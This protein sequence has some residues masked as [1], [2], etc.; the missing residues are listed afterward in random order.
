MAIFG[1]S[2]PPNP[3]KP[4]LGCIVVQCI[5]LLILAL[6]T[7]QRCFAQPLSV[8]YD[9]IVITLYPTQPKAELNRLDKSILDSVFKHTLTDLFE[10]EKLLGYKL[11]GTL[12]LELYEESAKYQM[13]LQSHEVWKERFTSYYQGKSCDF[14]PIF[15]SKQEYQVHIQLRYFIAHRVLNEFLNGSSIRQK[16]TQSG[17]Y[18]FPSWIFQGL[19]AAWAGGY[20]TVAEDEHYYHRN[21]GA[22]KSPN[23]IEPLGAQVYGRKIWQQWIEQFG[24]SAITNFW[25][26]L[27]YTG[28]EEQAVEYLTG[29]TLLQWMDGEGL[30]LSKSD[31]STNQPALEQSIQD[32]SPILNVFPVASSQQWLVQSYVPD[33]ECWQILKNFETCRKTCFAYQKPHAKLMSDLAFYLVEPI[34]IHQN[35][36]STALQ[37]STDEGV[38][39]IEIDSAGLLKTIASNDAI[40]ERLSVQ[41]ENEGPFSPQII[42]PQIHAAGKTSSYYLKMRE[43]SSEKKQMQLYKKGEIIDEVIWCDTILNQTTIRGFIVETEDLVSFIQSYEN[44]WFV[45]FTKLSDSLLTR[46]QIPLNIRFANQFY[47]QSSQGDRICE[48]GYSQTKS[49]LN[50]IEV[51][52]ISPTEIKEM[53]RKFDPLIS[54]DTARTSI[55]QDSLAATVIS[56]TYISPYP[57]KNLASYAAANRVSSFSSGAFKRVAMENYLTLDQGGL[58]FSNE[59]SLN[60][61]YLA[62]IDPNGLYNHPLTPELRFY[63]S[64]PKT[65]HTLKA[66]MLSNLSLNRMALR[67]SQ[68][69]TIQNYSFVQRYEHRS[70]DFYIRETNLFHNVGDL[71][72]V[73]CVRNWRK[74]LHTNLEFE[75]QNDRLTQRINRPLPAIKADRQFGATS[76]KLYSSYEYV[77]SQ[78]RDI[79]RFRATVN[80]GLLFTR[81]NVEN[82]TLKNGGNVELNVKISKVFRPWMDVSADIKLRSSFGKI[83]RQYWIGGS[84]G[85][86]IAEPWTNQYQKLAEQYDLYVYREVGGYVRGFLTGTRLGHSSAVAN[87]QVNLKPFN[88]LKRDLTQ[89]DFV[90]Q[91]IFYGFLDVGTAYVGKSPKTPQNPFNVVQIQAPNYRM[92]VIAERSPWV[93]GSGLG[94]GSVILKMPIRYEVAWGLM[95]GKFRK[96]TQQVCMTWNF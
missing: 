27:K 2:T 18:N 43:I 36:L 35:P 62:E 44:Q 42:Q 10:F 64:N 41:R 88:V 89:S 54:S 94:I 24:Q 59:E 5:G 71:I 77:G 60:F 68:S 52:S 4:R 46:W 76:A 72:T 95:E 40:S 86:M 45:K 55:T 49:N 78:F 70:R 87:F 69:F 92:D 82:T 39:Y 28:K 58:T 3:H 85:W 75:Y 26:V 48:L 96:P 17:R 31:A 16:M 47:S 79:Y 7:P 25:F 20:N 1:L 50:W 14:Y 63:L 81:Y 38:R 11:T 73:G 65:G 22:F 29:G 8:Q 34:H 19:C 30:N 12:H 66:G 15:L 61:P 57:K 23:N 56:W 90:K 33:Q 37:L 13:A 74:N 6:T 93:V 80:G 32:P 21:L 84:Q 53:I 9:R 83:R 67:V 51:G 91:T